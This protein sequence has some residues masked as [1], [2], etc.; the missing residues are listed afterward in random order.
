MCVHICMVIDHFACDDICIFLFM[1]RHFAPAMV[2]AHKV[3]DHEVRFN[4]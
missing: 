3:M 4:K 2:P 1:V